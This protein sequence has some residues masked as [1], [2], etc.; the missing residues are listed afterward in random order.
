MPLHHVFLRCRSNELRLINVNI[1]MNRTLQ[2]D[3][4][5]IN[6]YAHNLLTP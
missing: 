5:G 2:F 4:P 6:I 3:G 1:I